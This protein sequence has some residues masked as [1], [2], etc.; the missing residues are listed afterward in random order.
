MHY[1][2]PAWRHRTR[3]QMQ[4]VVCDRQVQCWRCCSS[5]RPA[6]ICSSLGRTYRFRSARCAARAVLWTGLD[7]GE[8]VRV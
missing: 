8:C 4:C 6:G 7:L 5:S 3:C 1:Y 2:V